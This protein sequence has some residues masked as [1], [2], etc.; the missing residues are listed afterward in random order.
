TFIVAAP[1]YAPRTAVTVIDGRRHSLLLTPRGDLRLSLRPVTAARLWLARQDRI[2][3]THLFANVAE[4]HDSDG[5]GRIEVRDLD[6]DASYVGVVT[7]DGRAPFVGSFRELPLEHALSLEEGLGVSGAVRD[8]Q[9]QPIAGARVEAMG[10]IAALDNFRYRQAGTSGGDGSFRVVGLLAGTVRARKPPPRPSP[11]SS[12]Q[13]VT[14][15]S[16]SRTRPA[17]RW[18]TPPST[19]RTACTGPTPA[20]VSSSPASPSARRS[21]SRSSAAASASG[22]V[23][24][25]PSARGSR[26]WSR[27]APPSSAR[28]CRRGASRPER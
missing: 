19:S 20:A 7:A 21:R 5:E 2:N 11:S 26:S 24:S 10:E 27:G 28:C 25:R 22:R 13:V 15:C 4:T 17:R 16:R 8:Q 3:V 18:P 6:R 9:G 12:L 14:S 1:G 23:S